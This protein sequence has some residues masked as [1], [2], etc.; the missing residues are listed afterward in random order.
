MVQHGACQPADTL[1]CV[2][3]GALGEL[4]RLSLYAAW[5]GGEHGMDGNRMGELTQSPSQSNSKPAI[6]LE[7]KKNAD[8]S[9]RE[10]LSV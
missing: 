2:E 3:P 8:I 5:S 7:N 4:L 10:I 6:A 9:E 1:I